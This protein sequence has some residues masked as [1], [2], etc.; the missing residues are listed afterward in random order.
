MTAA[1]KKWTIAT[2]RQ[3]LPELVG[4]AAREPQRVYRR[5]RLV[6]AVVSPELADEVEKLRRPSLAARL[7]ELQQLCAEESYVLTA[8][9][10]QDRANPFAAPRAGGHGRTR[11]ARKR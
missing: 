5:D 2:A 10:R 1:K 9:P 8:P 7:A 3:H 4:L 11:R 6:A